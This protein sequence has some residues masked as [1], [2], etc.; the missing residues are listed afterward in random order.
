MRKLP[1]V[2]SWGG[3]SSASSSLPMRKVPPG[4]G[5]RNRLGQEHVPGS[6]PK[7]LRNAART[8]VRASRFSVRLT[9]ATAWVSRSASSA[10]LP[11]GA[12]REARELFDPLVF[13][14]LTSLLG[15]KLPRPVAQGGGLVDDEVGEPERLGKVAGPAGR[16][17]VGFPARGLGPEPGGGGPPGSPDARAFAPR[18]RQHG[19][20]PPC[21]Q[22]LPPGVDAALPPH[23]RRETLTDEPRGGVEDAHMDPVGL[24]RRVVDDV[25]DPDGVDAEAPDEGLTFIVFEDGGPKIRGRGQRLVEARLEQPPGAQRVAA[26]RGQRG[27]RGRRQVEGGARAVGQRGREVGRK[28]NKGG[29]VG[30][31]N[32][33]AGG[34]DHPRRQGKALHAMTVAPSGRGDKVQLVRETHRRY[35][36]PMTVIPCPR[37]GTLAVAGTILAASLVFIDG[38]ALNVALPLIQSGLNAT[39]AD[40]LWI[41]NGYLLVPRGPHPPGRSPGRPV[42]TPPGLHARDRGVSGGVGVGAVCPRPVLD[43]RRPGVFKAWAAPCSSPEVWRC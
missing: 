6:L 24:G 8:S 25:G 9:R 14:R 10:V 19:G 28:Q 4:T 26:R 27:A 20:L 32:G 34:K 43:D 22:G 42:G 1:T 21:R 38:T 40:L 36:V 29:P 15:K 23:G 12:E 13:P 16:V 31:G 30:G 18:R 39:A 7:R 33:G 17:K 5:S 2:T 3:L 41:V 37:F 11:A 35:L